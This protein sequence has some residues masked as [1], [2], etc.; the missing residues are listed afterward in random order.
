MSPALPAAAALTALASLACV[1]LTALPMFEDEAS[2]LRWIL[3]IIEA[4]EWLQPLGDGKPLEAWPMVPLVRLGLPP[5]AA[6]RGVHVLAGIIAALLT[7]ALALRSADRGSA[8]V[9]GA[10]FAIC[11]FAVYLE[12]LALSDM[13]LC[14]AGTWV[15]VNVLAFLRSPT[16]SRALALSGS[17]VLA[18]LCKLPVGF[19][20]LM[21]APLALLFMPPLERGIWLNGRA[22]ARLLAAHAPAALMALAMVSAA[23]LRAHEGR[24]PGFGLADLFGIGMGGY[25]DIAAVIGVARV[26]LMGELTAQ[27]SWPVTALAMI[28]LLAGAIRGDWR[29]RWLIGMG[30]LP[31]LSI[32]LLARFWF[33]RY[34]LFA[35]P[36]LLIGAVG[37]WRC[38]CAHAGRLRA[39]AEFGLLGLCAAMMGR[40]SALLILDP[41][42][43]GW[44]AVD[45][46]Q[47]FEGWGSGYGYPQA[48]GFLA[49]S[50]DAPPMIYSLDGHGAY[51]LRNYLPPQWAARIAPVFYGPDASMLTSDQQRI[52]NLERRTPVWIIVPD[53]L[54]ESSL[55]AQFG[56]TYRSRIV[57]RRVAAFEKPG[58]RSR[59]CIYEVGHP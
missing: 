24:S 6:I 31:L 35:L 43:A 47:Y 18:A 17:L 1:R 22:R 50:P 52:A 11:P 23:L 55:R 32:S 14:A 38:L 27:L 29:L 12:R 46:F 49:A 37:G 42:K 34:L 7:Y 33:S 44:S 13:L 26:S 5:L 9:C 4:N 41:S 21:A 28:G 16:W 20:F 58:R 51:Q 15:L 19:V 59:L 36:P 56:E 3:R 45:R 40:Q 53:A 10:L 54:L 25:P 48:A 57:L 2:Q 39:P 8:F 30:M